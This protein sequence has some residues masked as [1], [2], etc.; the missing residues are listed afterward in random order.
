ME[1]A[2]YLF[3]CGTGPRRTTALIGAAAL[4]LLPLTGIAG[5]A[6]AAGNGADDLGAFTVAIEKEISAGHVPGAVV[7]YGENGQLRYRAALGVRATEP[8]TQT[9]DT[10]TI[11]DLASLTKVVATTT[12]IMQL[13][14][15]GRLE[16]DRPAAAYWPAFAKNGKAAITVRQLLTHS[17]G[18]P[19]DL[20]LT[21]TWAGATEGLARV[22]AIH[23][24][25]PPGARFLYS[26][27][28]FIVLGELVHRVSGE[29]LDVY[30][31]NHIFEP[32]GMH[33][34]GFRPPQSQLFRIAGTDREGGHLRRG[35]VQDPTAFRMG[36]VAGHAGLFSTAGDLS[37]FARMMLNRGSLDGV[38]ILKP[39]TVALMT[40]AVPLPGGVRRG[41]GWDMSSAY[42]A[43]MDRAFGP[44]SYGHTG[45]T[46]CLIW[47]EPVRRSFLI[48]MASRLFPD[49]GGDAMPLRRAL[50]GRVA[51]R[52]QDM[53]GTIA[54]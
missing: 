8:H 36:G 17:S 48:V 6:R 53:D 18:L 29:P 19:A 34:T 22:A 47:M 45:Y 46:G 32:L 28:N 33:D 7:L 9:L 16:L 31:R 52:H 4:L 3:Q 54:R 39:E 24:A 20:D 49:G 10:D 30:A 38:Q 44:G 14:E 1:R 35:E 15:T 5:P 2:Q 42:S 41:L 13:V 21:Q 51:E 37:R 50:A 23:P 12:A 25:S 27:I 11:F 43:G 26:D 40:G